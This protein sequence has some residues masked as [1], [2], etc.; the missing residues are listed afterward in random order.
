MRIRVTDEYELRDS[1]A[2]NWQV[3]EYREITKKDGSV[4]KEWTPRAAYF[5]RLSGALDW[6]IQQLPRKRENGTLVTLQDALKDIRKMAKEVKKYAE[7]F[8]EEAKA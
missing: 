8:E 3:F 4:V 6:I 7:K 2:L 1:D 5:S